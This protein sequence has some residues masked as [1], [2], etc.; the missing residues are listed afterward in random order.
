MTFIQNT[1]IL[2]RKSDKCI[3]K[4]FFNNGIN[5]VNFDSNFELISSN[6]VIDNIKGST[7]IWFDI[8]EQDNIYGIYDDKQGSLIKIDINDNKINKSSIISYDNYRYSRI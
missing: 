8:D 2:I 5:I 3:S 7:D 4:I 6:K 1:E